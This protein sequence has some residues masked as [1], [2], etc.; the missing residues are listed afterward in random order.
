VPDPTDLQLVQAHLS[1]DKASL[2][3]LFKRYFRPIYGYAAGLIG[4]EEADDVVQETFIRAW[5]HLSTF[6]TGRVFKTWL[7]R[8]AHNAA[9]DIMKKK[10]PTAFSDLDRPEDGPTIEETIEDE[11]DPISVL[12]DHKDAADR[13]RKAL[14]ALPKPQREVLTLH[15]LEEL[16]FSEI[17]EM[18]EQP[19]DTVKSRARRALVTVKKL[20]ES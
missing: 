1:G 18:L 9:I 2:G 14:D 10:R 5:R 4:R 3:I 13:L 16:T 15:Y 7:Y 12:L 8:I 19:L 11:T 6:D 20:L 17:G